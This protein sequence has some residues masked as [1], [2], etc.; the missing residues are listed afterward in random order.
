MDIAVP[1]RM[2]PD[3]VEE[4]DP[5]PD[6]GDIDRDWIEFV[7]NEYDDHAIEEALLAKEADN[8]VDSVTV[9][10]LDTGNGDIDQ[11]LYMASA[12]GA[13][14]LVKISGAPEGVSTTEAAALFS[15]YLEDADCDAVFTGVQSDE[16]RDG[17]LGPKLGSHLDLPHISVVTS[18]DVSGDA[19][20]VEKEFSGGVTADYEVD[21]P[22]VVGIQAAKEPP[23]YVP[24][25]QMQN[26]MSSAEIDEVGAD[27]L[28][29]SADSGSE[30]IDL[31]EPDT[32]ESAEMIMG[33][34][35]D[36]V[37]ELFDKLAEEGVEV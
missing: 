35:D 19:T 7:V 29:V 22:A 17:Q 18:V 27:D 21:L 1:V 6:G 37:D 11:T 31:A 24:V 13:D 15:A 30:I 4:L 16:D 25:S 20:M 3:P 32:G 36:A 14:E 9:V 34:A 23:R 12:K 33:S 8:D 2:V 28:G 26:A 10:G 5:H